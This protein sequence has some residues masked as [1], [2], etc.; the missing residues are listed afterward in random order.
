MSSVNK[1]LAIIAIMLSLVVT[2]IQVSVGMG[3]EIDRVGGLVTSDHQTLL[4]SY[5]KNSIQLRVVDKHGTI[6]QSGSIDR[7]QDDLLV[8]V[9]DVGM[10]SSN[11][12]YLLLDLCDPRTGKLERQD[13]A[14]YNLSNHLRKRIVQ[15]TL[16]KDSGVRYRWMSISSAVVLMGTNSS[17]KV[18]TREAYDPAT[19]QARTM[20]E[21]QSTRTYSIDEK[22]GIYEAVIAGSSIAYTSRSGKVFAASEGQS[23]AR[24]IYPARVLTTVMYPL[25][26]APCDT[27]SVYIGEQESGDILLLSLTSGDTQ[28]LKSGTEPFRAIPATRR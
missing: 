12:V 9:A 8:S 26:I 19:F 15:H 17:E 6:Q 14:L 27:D 16:G 28:V 5:E 21:P 10:D 22:E 20:P 25:F 1:I 4:V 11:T 13:L 18:L 2:A 3:T 7:M 24:E 23:S